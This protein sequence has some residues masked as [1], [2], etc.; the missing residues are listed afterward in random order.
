MLIQMLKLSGYKP[1]VAVVGSS[2]KR[3]ACIN[4]GADFVIDKSTANLWEEARKA[5][6]QLYAAIFDANGV[7]TLRDSYQHLARCGRLVLYGFHSNLPKNSSYLSPLHWGKLI[8]GLIALPRFDPMNLVLESKS[9]AGFNLSFFAEED[10]LIAAYMTQLT[11]WFE[12]GTI[13]APD[14]TLFEMKDVRKAHELI[15]SGQTVG[16][17][18]VKATT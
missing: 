9:V 7:E 2:S 5:S 8:Y 18:V 3:A 16:K 17:L 15:Q 10:T 4:M 1:I 6:P 13:R 14:I 12:S 11:E